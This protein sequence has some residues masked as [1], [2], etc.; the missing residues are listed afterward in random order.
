LGWAL[1]TNR[2]GGPINTPATLCEGRVLVIEDELRV[3][4]VLRQ[5]LADA[6][7]EVSMASTGEQG[8]AELEQGHFDLCVMDLMLPGI[9]GLEILAALRQTSLTTKVIVLSARD[10]AEDRL[11]GLESGADDYVVKPFSIAELLARI[12]I[13]LRRSNFVPKAVLEIADL[14]VN[15][16]SR[17]VIRGKR[18]VNLTPREYDILDY[19]LRNA[20]G[21]VTRNMLVR[22]VWRSVRRET[23]I[24]NLIDVHI[25]HLRRKLNG[26]GETRLLHTV[27]GIGFLLAEDSELG[28]SE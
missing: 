17:Q 9:G 2:G 26:P 4:A 23:P 21:V 5:S 8:L 20:N 14:R 13:L 3:A 19:L 28:S 1:V 7:Y 22:D 18:P 24:D 10:S 16:A 11:L 27:R 25:A 6:G 15:C 12:R